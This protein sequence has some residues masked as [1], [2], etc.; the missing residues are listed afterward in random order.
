MKFKE[1]IEKAKNDPGTELTED[2]IPVIE[3]QNNAIDKTTLID[4]DYAYY[5]IM[6]P[7]T[8]SRFDIPMLSPLDPGYLFKYIYYMKLRETSPDAFRKILNWD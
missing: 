1:Y 3:P 5:M 7:S 6:D 4:P 8:G 2:T